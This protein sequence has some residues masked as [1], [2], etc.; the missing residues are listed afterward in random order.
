[1]PSPRVKWA[2]IATSPRQK[3]HHCHLPSEADGPLPD[4]IT[5]AISANCHQTLLL[6]LPLPPILSTLPPTTI[7]GA[8]FATTTYATATAA[9]TAANDATLTEVVCNG[10]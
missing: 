7:S 2:E 10:N 9:I 6:P 1:M 3:G 8:A 5:A 4:A